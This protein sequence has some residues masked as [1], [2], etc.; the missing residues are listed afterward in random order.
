M[1]EIRPPNTVQVDFKR[2][3]GEGLQANMT[4]HYTTKPKALVFQQAVQVLANILH[5]IILLYESN[6]K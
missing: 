1:T 5:N 6:K 4:I 3:R 2:H